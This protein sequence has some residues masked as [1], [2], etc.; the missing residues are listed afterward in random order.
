MSMS[1]NHSTFKISRRKLLG[2]ST[3]LAAGGVVGGLVVG[4]LAGYLAGSQSVREVEKTVYQTVTMGGSTVTVARTQTVT[5]TRTVAGG[6]MAEKTLRIGEIAG[7][8]GGIAPY[9]IPMHNARVIA[10]EEI[11]AAGGIVVGDTRYKLELVSV[12]G[13][14]R[15][16][17][18]AA[19]ERFVEQENIKFILDGASSSN[20]YALG[21]IIKEKHPRA[22][23]IGAGGYD[24]DTT[25]GIPN[26]FRSTFDQKDL[27]QL[28]IQW[29]KDR[30][31]KDLA[32][33]I[34]KNHADAI[35]YVEQLLPRAGLN[36]VADER[37]TT[38]QADFAPV[39]TKLRGMRFDAI[40][41]HG[42]EPDHVNILKQARTLG[43]LPPKGQAPDYIW[44][45][46]SLA[47]PDF[48]GPMVGG[49][50][51]YYEGL[52]MD[53][54]GTAADLP[55]STPRIRYLRDIYK[56]KFPE[57]PY[58]SWVSTGYDSVY[59]LVRAIQKAGTVDDV[60]KVIDALH[61]L[62]IWDVPELTF[63]YPPGLIFDSEGQAH[64]ILTIA[65]WE[66]GA[67]KYITSSWETARQIH[68]PVKIH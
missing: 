59:I 33:L 44:I 13:A 40:I 7:L 35:L 56:K 30:G 52:Y 28:E 57:S 48:G 12:D 42:F 68:D 47:E 15:D 50:I 53:Q 19:L 5:E 49:D 34:D 41:W 24:P 38:G 36:V 26:F 31:V 9:G 18:I 17:A 54:F 20:Y 55:N 2:V 21:P 29:L 65:K 61:K 27:F 67:F 11:N 37:Y 3:Y 10:V 6:G 64:P 39:L 63:N 66:N 46:Q 32:V 8:S 23:V 60:P 62:T 58:V 1:E 25:K 43:L 4:G 14:R 16:D 45:S 51:S 22:L